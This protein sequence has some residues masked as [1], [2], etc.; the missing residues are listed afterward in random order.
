MCMLNGRDGYMECGAWL[1]V[2]KSR[3]R[4]PAAMTADAHG[5]FYAFGLKRFRS[6]IERV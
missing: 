2:A 4:C 5:A 1:V 3:L 6:P